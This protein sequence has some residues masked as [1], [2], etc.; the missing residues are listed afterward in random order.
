MLNPTIDSMATIMPPPMS[1]IL[2]FCPWDIAMNT[3]TPIEP[4]IGMTVI[5]TF[6]MPAASG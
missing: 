6:P 3:M 1:S 2:V 4:I 5:K